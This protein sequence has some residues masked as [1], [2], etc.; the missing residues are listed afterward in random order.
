MECAILDMTQY[1]A[2]TSCTQA[3]AWLGAD[4]VKVEQPGVGDPGRGVRTGT[5]NSPYFINWNSNKR[6]VTINL[7]DPKG[8]ELLLEMLPH[9]DVFVENYGPGVMERLNLTYEVMK[10]INPA[11]IYAR[12]KGFG[13]SG[14]WQDFKCYDMVAQAAAGAFSVTGEADGPP[15]M[16][17]STVGDSGTGTELALAITAAYVQRQRTGEGQF[18]EITMQEAMTYFMRTRIAYAQWGERVAPRNGNAAG[19]PTNLYPCKS[20]PGSEERGG[21]NEWVYIMVVTSRMWDTLCATIDRPELLLDPRFEDMWKRNENGQELYEEISKW[22]KRG[23]S[24]R[25]WTC[26]ARRACPAR[27]CS[28]PM[29]CSTTRTSRNAASST[30]SITRRTG[31]SACSAGRRGCRRATCRSSERRC[32]ASTRPRC[33]R[34]TSA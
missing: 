27:R 33:C 31:R 1:E 6:S 30:T 5:L 29:T 21:N 34:T 7:Q 10:E 8:R 20:T 19:A 4:V 3:L 26:W 13:L 16:P 18:I 9:Y 28:T 24:G 2:G 17:G 14:P 25:S 11:I 23:P 12:L 32:W 22:T 15:M